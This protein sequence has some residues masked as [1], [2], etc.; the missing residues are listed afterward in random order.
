MVSHPAVRIFRLFAEMN[1]RPLSGTL[2]HRLNDQ[3]E[4][5]RPAAHDP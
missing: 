2:L 1:D 4:G 3:N 5:V